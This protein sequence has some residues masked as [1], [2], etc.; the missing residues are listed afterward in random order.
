MRTAQAVKR[1]RHQ[2]GKAAVAG[3]AGVMSATIVK[4]RGPPQ[5]KVRRRG[6]PVSAVMP[7]FRRHHDI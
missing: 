3:R 2:V 7:P 1:R 4:S 6:E 5:V